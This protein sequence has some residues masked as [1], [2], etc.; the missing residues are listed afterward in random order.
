MG[1]QRTAAA[2]RRSRSRTRTRTRTRSRTADHFTLPVRSTLRRGLSMATEG[3]SPMM[4][5][6][7]VEFP[8][9][10]V[11]STMAQAMCPDS[12]VRSNDRW[13]RR[14]GPS[15]VVVG[16]CVLYLAWIARG[17]RCDESCRVSSARGAH[18]RSW[19]SYEDS[20]QWEAQ[21]V[22]A[23]IGVVLAIGALMLVRTRWRRAAFPALCSAVVALAVWIT[24]FVTD[25]A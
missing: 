22:L 17:L 4:R 24:W 25:I 2:G 1:A 11:V 10:G 3:P 7:G 12:T 21:F 18:D 15:A 16:G 6:C 19:T 8:L 13:V 23:A 20:W 9:G 14:L 5:S